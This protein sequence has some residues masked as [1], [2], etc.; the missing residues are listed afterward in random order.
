MRT[1]KPVKRLH[2]KARDKAIPGRCAL[3]QRPIN[4]LDNLMKRLAQIQHDS[5]IGFLKCSEL[6][7]KQRNRHEIIATFL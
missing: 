3:Y 1:A 4:L 2:I 7:F 6:A 5:I